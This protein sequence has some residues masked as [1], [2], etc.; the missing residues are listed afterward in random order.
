MNEHTL[1][2]GGITEH[3]TEAPL[4]KLS[5][6]MALLY[7]FELETLNM[8]QTRITKPYRGAA[9]QWWVSA[10]GVT[11]G[12]VPFRTA[13]KSLMNGAGEIAVLHDS[14]AQEDPAPWRA[15]AYRPY[16]L[17]PSV[18]ITWTMGFW[19]SSAFAGWAVLCILTPRAIEAPLE[20]VYWIFAL[21]FALSRLFPKQAAAL[22]SKVRQ[23]MKKKE[24]LP[25]VADVPVVP[26]SLVGTPMPLQFATQP[27]EK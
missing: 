18:A 12:P 21:G 22:G 10:A 23:A 17:R 25:G 27:V 16:W 24:L 15:I 20:I 8:D 13:L 9:D 14:A 3:A 19:A 6:P 2:G 5:T 1:L 26:S 7:A 4:D 11:D